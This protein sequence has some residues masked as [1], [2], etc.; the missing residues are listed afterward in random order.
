ML[1]LQ[2]ILIVHD[3]AAF[4]ALLQVNILSI[5]SAPAGSQLSAQVLAA[6]WGINV[7]TAAR[8]I[9]TTT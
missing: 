1:S 9:E 7:K 4:S 2:Q 3:D 5:P 6:N 8:T